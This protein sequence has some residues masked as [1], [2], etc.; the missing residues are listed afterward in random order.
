[1]TISKA[2]EKHEA[3]LMRLPNVVG[4]GIGDKAGRAVI[5]V[6]VTQKVAPS[7]L[8]PHETIPAVIEGYEVDVIAIGNPTISP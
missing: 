1:M 5:T 7:Q 4:V 8:Q 3:S 6:L 2:K